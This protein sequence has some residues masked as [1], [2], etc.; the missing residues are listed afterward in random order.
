MSANKAVTVLR[1]P[2]SASG[3]LLSGVTRTLEA[4]PCSGEV[5][6][7]APAS[8]VRGAPHLPQ[9]SDVSGFSAFH[10]AQCFASAFPPFAQKLLV[11]GLFVPHFEQ[12][13][14]APPR[15]QRLTGFVSPQVGYGPARP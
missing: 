2:S 13:T 8:F 12:R 10:F 11:E 1:S 7:A 15:S 9:K 6:T 5:A 14:V 3:G 4:N